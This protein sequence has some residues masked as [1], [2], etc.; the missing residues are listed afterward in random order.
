[1]TIK[2][3]QLKDWWLSHLEE[4]FQAYIKISSNSI[5]ANRSEAGMYAVLDHV[6]KY[7]TYC[8]IGVFVLFGKINLET[9]VRRLHCPVAYM[10]RSK[11]RSKS[12]RGLWKAA[13]HKNAWR[14]GRMQV[15][16]AQRCPP[17][18]KSNGAGFAFL[19]ISQFEECHRP[20]GLNSKPHH[21][22]ENGAGKSTLIK[23]LLG[24][25]TPQSGEISCSGSATRTAR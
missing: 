4:L 22:G 11:A 3:Y 19:M 9:G 18:W 17:A 16:R 6:L 2:L 25:E 24:M 23:L 15:P 1:M 14:S 5:F 21:Q 8:L 10:L 13:A 7:G 20:H 12:I